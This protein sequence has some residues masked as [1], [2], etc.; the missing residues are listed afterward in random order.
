MRASQDSILPSLPGG[1]PGGFLGVPGGFLGGILSYLDSPS[2]KV[3]SGRSD[4]R[5]LEFFYALFNSALTK[6]VLRGVGCM[7]LRWRGELLLVD[8]V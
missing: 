1:V 3:P 8:V 6:S 4:L 7:F 2:L 5:F